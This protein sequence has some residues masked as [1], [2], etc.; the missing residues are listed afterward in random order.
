[1]YPVVLD[2]ARLPAALVGS[3][4][5]ARR[6]LAGLEAGGASSVTVYC[7]EP[8]SALIAAAGP[9]LAPRYPDSGDLSRAR[10]LLVCGL[11][12]GPASE[13]AKAARAIGVLVNVEDRPQWCD[14][15]L[16]SI[17]R[18]GDLTIAVSTGGQ[19]P[20]LARRVRRF[21]ES[22]IGPEW[23]SRLTEIAEKR[24]AWRASGSDT[25]SVS[26]LTNELIDQRGW[27]P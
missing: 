17:S 26:R 13:L 22:Q 15:H 12:D 9:R 20:G 27:L 2:L 4:S 5:A 3:A 11:D 18:R 21:I 10:M 19:S 25:A 23:S 16:P 24:A 1:M 7:P 8:D 6:R 14:F